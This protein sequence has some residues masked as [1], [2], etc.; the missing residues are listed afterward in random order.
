MDPATALSSF[1]PRAKRG[2]DGDSVF[3]DREAVEG[4]L[5]A[6]ERPPPPLRGISPTLRA[7]EESDAVAGETLTALFNFSGFR[8]GAVSWTSKT[9]AER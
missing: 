4:E 8:H 6:A 5:A 1:L 2:G 7:G 3:A 9:A